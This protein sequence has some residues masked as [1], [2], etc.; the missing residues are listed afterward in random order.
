MSGDLTPLS[1]REMEIV[2]LLATGASNHEIARELFISVNTVKVHLRN[3]FQKLGVE[4]RTEATTYAVRQGW[5]VLEGMA[6]SGE[7]EEPALPRQRIGTWQRVFFVVSAL[8]LAVLAFVPPSRNTSNRADSPFTDHAA[9][10][11]AAAPDLASTRWE[12]RVR[13]C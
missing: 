1:D 7:E 13:P 6:P 9:N 12:T 2:R 10:P 11:L 8:L 4:S 5:V 3:I